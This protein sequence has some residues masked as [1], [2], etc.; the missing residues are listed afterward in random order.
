MDT[1][2]CVKL[3]L[4]LVLAISFMLNSIPISNVVGQP[5]LK[6]TEGWGMFFETTGDINIT[7][8]EPVVAVRIELPRE[9][10]DGVIAKSNRQLNN[11]TYFIRSDISS[12][13][14]YYTINDTSEYY[15]YNENGPY[16]ITIQKPPQYVC[17]NVSITSYYQNFTPSR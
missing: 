16:N 13:Y 9:F 14:Y 8:D 11:D 1:N 3:V 12:D 17:S 5:E 7:I 2:R 15:P 6:P 10:L 4:M